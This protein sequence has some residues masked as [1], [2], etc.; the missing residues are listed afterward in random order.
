MKLHIYLF[1]YLFVCG[2]GNWTQ[3][4]STFEQGHYAPS[5]ILFFVIEHMEK[6]KKKHSSTDRN[7]L[8][9][10]RGSWERGLT[11]EKAHRSQGKPP[12]SQTRAFGEALEGALSRLV[13]VGSLE[14]ECPWFQSLVPNK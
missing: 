6:R 2:T 13:C 12:P 3:G 4:H 10:W 5:P 9:S 1:I 14:V 7:R 11:G 8:F